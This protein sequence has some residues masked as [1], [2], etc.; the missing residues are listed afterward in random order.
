MTRPVK[1]LTAFWKYDSESVKLT[2]VSCNRFS[3]HPSLRSKLAQDCDLYH[4]NFR[5]D[6]SNV[7]GKCHSRVSVFGFGG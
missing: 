5:S 4:S 1:F 7:E 6:H 2:G 3:V